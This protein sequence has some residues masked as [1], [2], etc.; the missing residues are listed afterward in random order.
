MTPT[1]QSVATKRSQKTVFDLTSFD[2][3]KLVKEYAVPQKPAS[4]EE[5]LAAVGN[6]QTRLLEVIHEGLVAAAGDNAYKDNSGWSIEA[7]DGTVQPYSG[8]YADESKTKLINGAVLNLAKLQAGGSWDTLP[9]E[10]KAAFKDSAIGMLRAN[11]DMLK[12]IAG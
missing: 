4:I 7:E 5:A 6:D 9:K 3:I 11:P 2:D 8:N 1:T 10:K 12:S